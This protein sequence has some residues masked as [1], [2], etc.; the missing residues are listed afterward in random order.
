MSELPPPQAPK[1]YVAQYYGPDGDTI[2][3]TCVGY[4]YDSGT[5]FFFK[6]DGT[7]YAVSMEVAGYV[8][9]QPQTD[10]EGTTGGPADSEQGPFQRR[11]S[12]VQASWG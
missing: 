12:D 9:I 7:T 10:R 1:E 11:V 2:T 6:P 4:T 8:R 5:Y 3:M